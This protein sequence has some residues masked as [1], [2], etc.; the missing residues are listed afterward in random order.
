MIRSDIISAMVE[1]AQSAGEGLLA[2]QSR[3]A[4]LSVQTKLGAADMFTEADLKAE[5]TVK[6][7]LMQ[8]AP[9][10]G[11]LGE[12]GG[13][14]PGRDPDHVWIVDPLDGTTNFLT[15]S[16]LF[17]VNVALARKGKVIA[18]VTLVPAMGEM[19]LAE[20]GQGAWLNGHP[21]TVSQRQTL[22]E[23]VL[24]VGI[25]FATKP[26]HEQFYAEMERLTDRVAGIRRLGAGAIDMAWVACGRYDAY[27]EQSVSAWDMAAGAIIV[28]EAGGFV[29]STAGEEL[30]LMGGTVLASTLAVHGPLVEALRPI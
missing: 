23:A 27:W 30:D 10:Y 3:I 6:A 15:G 28:R 17:A 9:D 1:A 2:D 18:G 7:G 4:S 26:R 19:F 22:G 21:I 25:P 29:S 14:Q 11:F 12:E 8:F 5:A 13:L 20:E 24:G 16:P